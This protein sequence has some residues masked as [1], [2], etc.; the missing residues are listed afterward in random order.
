MTLLGIGDE[1]PERAVG[2]VNRAAS[3]LIAALDSYFDTPSSAINPSA[4][5]PRQL[6]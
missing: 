2:R 6:K 1:L 4:N 3:Q 5:D